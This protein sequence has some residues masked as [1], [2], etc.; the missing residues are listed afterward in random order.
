[1]A[2]LPPMAATMNLA[3]ATPMPA[4][5]AFE[6]EACAAGPEAT[7]LKESW[8]P[9][10][11]SYSGVICSVISAPGRSANGDR[12]H[13]LERHREL[14]ADLLDE[15]DLGRPLLRAAG[16]GARLLGRPHRAGGLVLDGDGMALELPRRG[17]VARQHFL[18][19]QA[20]ERLR[21]RVEP[22]QA[23]ERVVGELDVAGPGLDHD[24][25][26]GALGSGEQTG[27]HEVQ[28]LVGL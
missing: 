14:L 28:R 2:S 4:S 10:S 17:R 9:P 8:M 5:T 7:T 19:R 16:A 26:G 6:P 27:A 18:H 1:M 23:H 20:G 24:R 21:G 13:A 11:V 22:Q 15:R 12:R 25:D 3:T